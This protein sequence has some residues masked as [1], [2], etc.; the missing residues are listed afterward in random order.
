MGVLCERPGCGRVQGVDTLYLG[1]GIVYPQKRRSGKP[2]A[3]LCTMAWLHAQFLEPLGVA[4][5]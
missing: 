1:G 5:M 3:T 4:S 2:W